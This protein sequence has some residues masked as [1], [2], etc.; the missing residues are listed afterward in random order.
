VDA[1]VVFYLHFVPLQM[2]ELLVEQ[3]DVSLL[4]AQPAAS[5]LWISCLELPE[6]LPVSMLLQMVLMTR[7]LVNDGDLVEAVNAHLALHA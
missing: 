4:Y 2:L 3:V 5:D 7:E 6:D 1:P